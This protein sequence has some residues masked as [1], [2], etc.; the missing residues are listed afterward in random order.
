MPTTVSFTVCGHLEYVCSGERSFIVSK[1]DIGF[2]DFLMFKTVKGGGCGGCLI[3]A[4][5]IIGVIVLFV[6]LI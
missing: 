2:D 3:S 5:S 4:L 1:N 6:I